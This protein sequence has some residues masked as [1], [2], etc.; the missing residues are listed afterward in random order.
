MDQQRDNNKDLV[1]LRRLSYRGKEMRGGEGKAW[2][3]IA[4]RKRTNGGKKR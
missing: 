2:K 4:Y 3:W 1:I